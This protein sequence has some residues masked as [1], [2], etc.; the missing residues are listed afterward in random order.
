MIIKTT[1]TVFR[2]IDVNFYESIADP[3]VFFD[4][5]RMETPE[6][7]KEESFD[8]RRY[9]DSFIGD[10]QYW[11]DDV[12]E[13]LADYGIKS[14]KVEGI[15]NP[16][17][18][19]FMSDWADITVC[20]DNNWRKIAVDKLKDLKSNRGCYEYFDSHF[21]TVSGYIFFGPE[22]W[23]DFKEALGNDDTEYCTDVLFGMYSTLAFVREFGSVACDVW[24]SITESMMG[25]LIYEEFATLVSL[26]PEDS[27]YLFR[28]AYTAEADEIYH[29]VLDKYGW[30]WR[31]PKY[32]SKTELCAMLKWAKDKG[33]TIN[34]LKNIGG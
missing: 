2:F 29:N 13:K 32:K 31:D 23:D 15:G 4:K 16:R 7:M 17:E 12:A 19:N 27:E 28:D 3:N 25:N 8:D 10:I 30:A 14:I 22:S 11:A 1:T 26:I 9:Q 6:Y 18:Y 33:M 34:D 24:D 21:K 5:C 20:V